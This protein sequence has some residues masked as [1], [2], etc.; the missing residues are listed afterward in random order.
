MTAHNQCRCSGPH[1]CW[2]SCRS[3]A[4]RVYDVPGKKKKKKKKIDDVA[5]RLV[6]NVSIVET[7]TRFFETTRRG[8]PGQFGCG[9][10]R[11]ARRFDEEVPGPGDGC[12]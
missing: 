11:Q 12:R 1:A 8:G 3:Q 4:V 7:M 9:G 10:D 5:S 6:K 2:I